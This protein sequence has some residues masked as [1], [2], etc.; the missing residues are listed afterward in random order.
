MGLCFGKMIGN[1][2][3]AMLNANFDRNS[4]FRFVK[5]T[6]VV[7]AASTLSVCLETTSPTPAFAADGASAFKSDYKAALKE[8]EES[9]LPL[10]L[11]FYADWC[12]PCQRMER[13]VFSSSAVKDQLTGHFVAVKVNSDH[14][15]DLVARYGVQTLPSDVV[16]DSLTG[17]VIVI[18]AGFQDRNNYLAFVSQ[19]ESRFLKAHRRESVASKTVGNGEL[20]KSVSSVKT[21]EPE[22]GEPK[23]M[24]GLDGFSPVA[25][26]KFRKWTHG[27][28]KLAWD[29]K[30]VTY[31]LSTR[32][33]L[34]EFR[35]NP[36]AYAP[37]LL[38]CDPVILW[39]SDK[40]VAGDIRYGAFFDDELFLF[41]TEERR[42]Q[43]RAN[44]EKY[45]RLQHALKADQIEQ[46]VI[47]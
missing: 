35:E 23:P 12:M 13:D 32:E 46:T 44:P 9:Q 39:E 16:V 10:L 41:K 45:I 29:Y 18:K 11:H 4:G 14:H 17:R 36:E 21:I 24:I 30:D 43:F 6:L 42:V 28:P 7:L 5:L 33:E 37:K 31:Y 8:A 38:G 2:D 3:R 40:A 25:L 20:E 26:S 34:V 19:A 1:G 15:Q 22:L 47:R 27:S